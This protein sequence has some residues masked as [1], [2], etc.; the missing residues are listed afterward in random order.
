[1]SATKASCNALDVGA[2]ET[3]SLKVL[4]KIVEVRTMSL[5]ASGG[6][7]CEGES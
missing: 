6:G 5:P 4:R 2:A 7:F 3:L 1:M